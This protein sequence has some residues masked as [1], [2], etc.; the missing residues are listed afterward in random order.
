MCPPAALFSESVQTYSVKEEGELQSLIGFEQD[1][2]SSGKPTKTPT[3]PN[4]MLI[5]ISDL[6]FIYLFIGTESKNFRECTLEDLTKRTK[7]RSGK[8]QR[9]M[10][11]FKRLANDRGDNQYY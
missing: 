4:F 7:I 3:T 1:S 6:L 10:L 2:S 8:D 11:E 5:L 9:D